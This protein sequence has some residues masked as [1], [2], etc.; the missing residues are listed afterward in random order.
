M[1]IVTKK[2]DKGKSSLLS[3]E[4]VS[5][6]DPRL[7]CVGVLDELTAA[8]GL[9]RSHSKD[10]RLSSEIREL[11]MDLMRAGAEISAGGKPSRLFEPISET[12]ISKIEKKISALEAKIALPKSFVIPGTTPCASAL[13]L[14]RAIARRVER[15]AV[16]MKDAKVYESGNLFIWLNRLSDYLF[17]LA[18]RAEVGE[19]VKFDAKE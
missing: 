16:A 10:K 14:S 19:G 3:G 8:L 9:A 17:M 5:K 2:G 18:R 13:E 7:I 12:D 6:A 1:G 11:Q 4:T 15:E